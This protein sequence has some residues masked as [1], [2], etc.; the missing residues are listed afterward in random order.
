MVTLHIL[1]NRP[2]EP[3]SP[4]GAGSGRCRCSLQSVRTDRGMANQRA[5]FVNKNNNLSMYCL[6]GSVL[7]FATRKSREL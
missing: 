4:S 7:A 6:V 5:A 2:L 3:G 1:A